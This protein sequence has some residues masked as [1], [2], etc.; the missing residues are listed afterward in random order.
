ML[1]VASFIGLSGAIAGL[2][3][4]YHADLP[5]VPVIVLCLGVAMLMS[6]ATGPFGLIRSHWP[7]R[8]HRQA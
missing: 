1:L 8:S 6:M 4:S 7:N 3:L 5:T 2:L